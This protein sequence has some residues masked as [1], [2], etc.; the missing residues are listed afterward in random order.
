MELLKLLGIRGWREVVRGGKRLAYKHVR[1][2]FEL[3]GLDA[4]VM[5]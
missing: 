3:R 2:C 4:F 5:K 1:R